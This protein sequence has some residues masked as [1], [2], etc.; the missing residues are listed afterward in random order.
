M[1]KNI[2]KAG[3]LSV[4]FFDDLMGADIPIKPSNHF[5]R[6]IPSVYSQADIWYDVLDPSGKMIGVVSENR[7]RREFEWLTTR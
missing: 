5:Y 6:L 3:C 4:R 2:R 7:L 1:T